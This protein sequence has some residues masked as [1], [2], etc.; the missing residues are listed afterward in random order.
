MPRT[1]AAADAVA[2]PSNN[3]CAPASR[4]SSTPSVRRRMSAT[5]G[6]TDLLVVNQFGRALFTDLYTAETSRPNLA[7]LPLPGR[8]SPGLLRRVGSRRSRRGGSTPHRGRPQPYDRSLTELVGE[9]STRSQEFR[10]WW[11]S[12]NVKLHRTS[13]KKMRHPIAGELELTGEALELPGD[14]GLT[15]ITYT[16]EPASPQP[17]HSS[18]SRAGPPRLPRRPPPT[19]CSVRDTSGHSTAARCLLPAT[20]RP[21]HPLAD[22]LVRHTTA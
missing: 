12:H 5:V 4:G 22:G 13:T 18:S 15:L 6:S 10:S 17:K 1:P 9:L 19:P 2:P 16:V 21:A 14:S 3:T 8:P 20:L 11:V 7:A